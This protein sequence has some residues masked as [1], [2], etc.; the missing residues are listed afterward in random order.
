MQV[1]IARDPR[2]GRTSELPSEDPIHS[3]IYGREMI[4]GMQQQDAKGHPLMMA[5][6]KHYTV[7][8]READRMHSEA[9]VTA[10]DLHDSYLR[11][12]KEAFK[13][14]ASGVMCSEIRLSLCT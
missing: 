13:A 7:Y 6:L 3:G 12:Y 8:S 2:F 4:S 10:Y 5:H 11:Q 9:N 14:N 1:N